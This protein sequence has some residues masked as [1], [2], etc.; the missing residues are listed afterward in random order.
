MSNLVFASLFLAA[1]IF[2]LTRRDRM[3]AQMLEAY[4]RFSFLRRIPILGRSHNTELFHRRL[5]MFDGIFLL[6]MAVVYLIAWV[7]SR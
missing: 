4:R 1:G 5:I 3:V 6:A 7:A 2:Y